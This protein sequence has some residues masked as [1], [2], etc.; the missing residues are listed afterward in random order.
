MFPLTWEAR[1]WSPSKTVVEFLTTTK[2][3]IDDEALKGPWI[4]A[5]MWVGPIELPQW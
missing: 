5:I 4:T 2:E 3:A 1:L